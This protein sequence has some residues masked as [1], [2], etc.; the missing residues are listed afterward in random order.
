LATLSNPGGRFDKDRLLAS[1][2]IHQNAVN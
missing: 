1:L 2:A